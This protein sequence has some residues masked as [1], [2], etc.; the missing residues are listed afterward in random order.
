[1]LTQDQLVTLLRQV[2][3]MQTQS[4]PGRMSR[5]IF[6]QL[7]QGVAADAL[8]VATPA[9]AGRTRSRRAKVARTPLGDLM[10]NSV[11]RRPSRKTRLQAGSPLGSLS[12]LND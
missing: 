12:Q 7:Q 2:A 9:T 10:A 1:M 4:S 11:E 3:T 5:R 8:L 6:A